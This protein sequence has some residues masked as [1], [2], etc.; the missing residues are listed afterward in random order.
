MIVFFPLYLIS[1]IFFSTE[2]DFFFS[3]P[4]FGVD[5]MNSSALGVIGFTE[6]YTPPHLA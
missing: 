6:I 3:A 2:F 5:D 4:I 1:I